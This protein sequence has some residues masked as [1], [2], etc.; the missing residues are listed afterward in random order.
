MA[1]RTVRRKKGGMFSLCAR[2][3]TCRRGANAAVRAV[4]GYALVDD[5]DEESNTPGNADQLAALK[6][7]KKE[8]ADAKA[9]EARATAE[10]AAAAEAETAIA[11]RAHQEKRAAAEKE[12]KEAREAAAAA[13]AAADAAAAER[14]RQESEA[15]RAR[16]A[17]EAE[18][19]GHE[20]E[21]AKY[22]REE[23]AART[24]LAKAEDK[25]TKV[26]PDDKEAQ[27]Q[28]IKSI[29]RAIMSAKGEKKRH[30]TAAEGIR[31]KL[32]GGRRRSTRRRKTRRRR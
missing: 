3:G 26:D 19:E 23:E 15:R 13:K 17:A 11:E 4:T 28:V 16:E 2:R 14:E 7:W 12:A 25:L 27:E 21:A 18:A 6:K 24:A 1:R 5:S 8:L 22:E 10:A 29:K 30:A 31:K 9:A 32:E 20:R